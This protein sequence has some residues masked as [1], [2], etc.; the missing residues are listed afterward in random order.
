MVAR[1]ELL[2]LKAIVE[3]P[4]GRDIE[5][6]IDML[7]DALCVAGGYG[8]EKAQ[9]KF[10]IDV[11]MGGDRLAVGMDLPEEQG[12]DEAPGG[13]HEVEVLHRL[14]ELEGPQHVPFDID[15]TGQIGIADAAFIDAHDGPHSAVVF[16]GHPE[17]RRTITETLDT[18]V[19]KGH[20]EG[21]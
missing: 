15:V 7:V 17:A 18:A 2:V 4:K 1:L 10:R 8:V 9:E 12:L 14:P 11:I 3:F 16:E 13:D 21:H 20:L 5:C 19:G 6:S